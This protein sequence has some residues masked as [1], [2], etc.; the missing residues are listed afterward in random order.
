[1]QLL[2]QRGLGARKQVGT[3][4]VATALR[5]LLRDGIVGQFEV[6]KLVAEQ[7]RGRRDRAG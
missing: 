1:V 4:Q 6:H 3:G 7:R 2:A 5:E